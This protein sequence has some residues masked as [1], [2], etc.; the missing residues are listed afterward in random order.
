[1]SASS[2]LRTAGSVP[3][4]N[5]QWIRRSRSRG[6]THGQVDG[7]EDGAEAG[8]DRLG[9]QLVGDAVVAKD[10]DLQEPRAVG[11]C[12]RDVGRARGRERREAERRADGCGGPGEALLPVRMRH[13]LVGHRSHDDGRGDAMAEHGRLGRRPTRSRRARAGAGATLR[14]R[15][16]SRASV[17]SAPAPPARYSAQSG[18]MRAAASASTS[19]QRQRRL[20]RAI[21]SLS[22]TPGR[23]SR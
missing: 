2:A 11:R 17:R 16:R 19:A 3:S 23:P 12:G 8:V 13:A 5:V 7:E 14:T 18:S 15:R 1:M 21:I 22:I 10:V 4:S 9:D 20:H 6:P